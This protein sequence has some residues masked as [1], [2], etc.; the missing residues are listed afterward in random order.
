MA[1]E[2]SGAPDKIRTCDLCLRRAGSASWRDAR[3]PF[4]HSEIAPN[5]LSGLRLNFR[6]FS[7]CALIDNANRL[8]FDSAIPRF[9]SWRPS[10]FL[11]NSA[12]SG[13]A[14]EALSFEP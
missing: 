14:T 1:K 4:R 11:R 9:E 2:L 13:A 7:E 3:F 12:I 6:H 5:L 8:D 10:Q